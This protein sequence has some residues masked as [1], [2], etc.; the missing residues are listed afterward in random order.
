[1]ICE[2]RLL[3]GMCNYHVGVK[4]Y[5]FEHFYILSMYNNFKCTAVE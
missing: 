4:V 5:H 3:E 2:K 1:M